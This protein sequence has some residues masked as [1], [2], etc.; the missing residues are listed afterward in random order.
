MSVQIV[1]GLKEA[2]LLERRG[3][4]FYK[5][6]AAGTQNTIVREFFETMADEEHRHMLVLEDQ[7]RNYH[8]NQRLAD[9]DSRAN[10]EKP[11]ADFVLTDL[12]KAQ[13][14]AASFEAAAISA[15]ML[16]EEQTITLYAD[17]AR[18]ST[19][20]N[21]KELFRWLANWEHGHLTFLVGLERDIREQVWNDRQF[22]PF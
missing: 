18:L 6:V 12:L 8:Q 5:Q 11:L 22:W 10:V 15:A 1:D 7:F 2:I 4:A 19:D 16:M 14:T 9:F 21:E 20:P 13:I 17:R 3:R